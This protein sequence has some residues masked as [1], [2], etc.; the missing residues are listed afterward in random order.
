MYN[1][2]T[3]ILTVHYDAGCSCSRCS[4]SITSYALILDSAVYC[5]RSGYI[6]NEA[7]DRK[8]GMPTLVHFMLGFGLPHAEHVKFKSVP[9]T[10]VFTSGETVTF[11]ASDK[12]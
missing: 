11:G 3:Y 5:P 7:L 8:S 1:Y 9:S 4:H 10:T 12:R 2:F 6:H